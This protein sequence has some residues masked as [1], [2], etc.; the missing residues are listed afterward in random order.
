[1]FTMEELFHT[2]KE[3]AYVPRTTKSERK[4][5]N[6][7]FEVIVRLEDQWNLPTH[8]RDWS[9]INSTWESLK[10]MGQERKIFNNLGVEPSLKL[11]FKEFLRSGN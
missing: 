2:L 4:G 1:M 9:I 3:R 11:Q 8:K 10:R 5:T 6:R 7:L